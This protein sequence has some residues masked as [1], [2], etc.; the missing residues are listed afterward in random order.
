MDCYAMRADSVAL[1]PRIGAQNQRASASQDNL[2]SPASGTSPPPVHAPLQKVALT[3]AVVFTIAVCIAAGGVF[4]DWF[5]QLPANPAPS[6]AE[7]L[8]AVS[9]PAEAVRPEIT[10]TD[11]LPAPPAVSLPVASATETP[12]ATGHEELA[13]PAARELIMQGWA[14]YYRPRNPQRG[15][16]V[17]V[18]LEGLAGIRLT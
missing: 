3:T 11:H 15:I 16:A 2:S 4:L 8:A 7:K 17:I 6:V 10:A 13:N 14:A 5:H 1:R 9:E 12:P 18:L